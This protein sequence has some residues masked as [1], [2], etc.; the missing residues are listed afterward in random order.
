MFTPQPVFKSVE[1]IQACIQKRL[2]EVLPKP[3]ENRL[4]HAMYTGVLAPGKRTRSVLMMLACKG[5]GGNPE[6]VLDLACAIEM[7]HTASLFLD[8]MPCMDNAQLRRGLPAAHVNYGQ[9][10]AMLAAVALLTEALQLVA[11]SG[12]LSAEV[13]SKLVVVLSQAVGSDGLAKGQYLDLHNSLYIRGEYDIAYVNE[14]KTCV[15]FCAAL[16]MAALAC[17]AASSSRA[18]LQAAAVNIGQAFQLRDDLEDEST[19]PGTHAKDRNKDVGKSTLVA[20]LGHEAVHYRMQKHLHDAVY[21][22]HKAIPHDNQM[23]EFTL[24][25]FGLPYREVELTTGSVES[26]NVHVHNMGRLVTG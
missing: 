13:R 19:G 14:K 23:V 6:D 5:L 11:S 22:L 9:D 3:D 15:L 25:A 2:R 21:Y 17:N 1:Q 18:S 4:N 26:N 20:L 10:V 16:D 24:R 8:D 7:V 12:N